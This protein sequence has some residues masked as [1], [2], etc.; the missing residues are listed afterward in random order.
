MTI[1]DFIALDMYGKFEHKCSLEPVKF[2]LIITPKSCKLICL[3]CHRATFY[4]AI[5][6]FQNL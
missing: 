2:Q 3:S 6:E 4:R 1:P 5:G